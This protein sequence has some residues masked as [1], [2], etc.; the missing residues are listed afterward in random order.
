MSIIVTPGQ[1]KAQGE[2]Y[3]QLAS[4]TAAGV[5]IMQGID[6]LRRNAP[7]R[8]LKRA[9]DQIMAGL[10]QGQTFAESLRGVGYK[11]PEFDAALIEAGESAGRLDQ[12]FRILG[13]FYKERGTMAS[14]V[15]S[16]LMY[17]LFLFHFAVFLFPVSYFTD[18]ILKGATIPFL[19]NKLAVLIPVYAIILFFLWIVRSDRNAAI[20]AF[21]EKV[22]LATPIVSGIRRSFSL[23]RLCAALEALI[24]AGVT[25]IEAWD[26]AAR[27]SGSPR[28]IHAVADVRPRIVSGELPS[29]AIASQGIYPDLFVSSYR[30]GEM[31]GQLD[32]ALRRLYRYY[33]ETATEGLNRF[34]EWMPRLIYLGVAIAIAYQI[35]S[36][37][38]GYFDTINKLTGP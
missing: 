38:S 14:K 20:R 10:V 15:L 33:Q 29:E 12:C 35:I 24:N 2:F 4:M 3:T 7:S 36:F 30:T 17:P 6:L 32:D 26:L 27:A 16:Q 8:K 9:A 37:Y 18:L 28:I 31:S 19:R 25:I 5:T 11:I 34:A 23:A 22:G 21:V 1:L 13:D